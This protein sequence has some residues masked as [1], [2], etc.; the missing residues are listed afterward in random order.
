M[1]GR[2]P[3]EA[4]LT[5]KDG[6]TMK[7]VVLLICLAALAVAAPALANPDNKMAVHVARHTSVNCSGLP[8]V[9]TCADIKHTYDGCGDIDVFPV[10]YDIYGITS[11]QVGLTWPDSWGSCAFT[12]CGFDLTIGGMAFPGDHFTGAWS[13][14]HYISS[15]I[16][17]VGWLAS[18]SGGIICPVPDPLG[19]LGVTDCEFIQHQASA[20]FC[21]G[22]CGA[23]GDDPCGGGVS[24]EKTWGAIKSMYR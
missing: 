3:S 16:V 22:A 20:I 4:I 7:N 12:P 6:D 14:C 5:H 23:S 8:V 21:A 17:G 9:R 19:V 1:F 15:H 10:V 18:S 11:I 2:V 13:E 24:E